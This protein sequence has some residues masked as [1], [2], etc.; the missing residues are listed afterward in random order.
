MTVNHPTPGELAHIAKIVNDIQLQYAKR[1]RAGDEVLSTY[2]I[3]EIRRL[4][5]THRN[6]TL[7]EVLEHKE[8][9]A[10]GEPRSHVDAVPVE[11]IKALMGEES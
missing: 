3:A 8:S 6:K 5:S 9:F 2:G 11:A 4:L 1:L 10:G 7:E